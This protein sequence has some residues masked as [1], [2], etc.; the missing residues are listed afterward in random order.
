M[1]RIIILTLL[2]L[3]ARMVSQNYRY[4]KPGQ[5]FSSTENACLVIKNDK[6]T[7]LFIDD[8]DKYKAFKTIKLVGFN[9]PGFD[10][11]S[12][13][14]MIDEDFDPKTLI[15]ENCDLSGLTEPLDMFNELE[16][17]QLLSNSTFYENTLFEILKDCPVKK[18]VIQ[19]RDAELITDSLHFL[20]DLNSLRLSSNNNFTLP[21]KTA[22]IQIDLN[23]NVHTIDLAYYGNFYKENKNKT[24]A[25]NHPSTVKQTVK[26]VPMACIKQ[27]I[28]GI[29]INDTVYNFNAMAGRKMLYESGSEITI[30]K[31]AFVTANGQNYTGNVK[32]F[33]R[34][35]RNPV[36][37]MLSGIPM[38]T[39]VGD[40]MELF[41]S[42]GMYEINAFD[43]N[44]NQLQARSDTSI[45]INFA[46]TDTS[47]SFKFYS[48][49]DNGS[50]TTTD[51]AVKP[52]IAK[53]DK[54]LDATRAVRE[55][56]GYLLSNVKNMA[57]TTSYEAR[58]V[59][60]NYLYTYRKDNLEATKDSVRYFPTYGSMF[61]RK[62]SRNKSFFRVKF[63][64]LTKDKE[65]IFTIVKANKNN[66]DVPKHILP[67]LNR[68]YLYTGSLTKEEFRATYNRKL[69]C[70]DLRL[71]SI[72]NGVD[73]KI[74]TDISFINLKGKAV[75]LMDDGTCY[76]SKKANTILCNA[77][78][79][80]LYSEAKRFNKKDRISPYN[81]NDLNFPRITADEKDLLAYNY[82][83]KYQNKDEKQ[84]DFSAW[85][86]YIKKV[87]PDYYYNTFQNNNE[88]GNALVKSGLGV[89]NIDA[90]IHSGQMEDILVNYN[91]DVDSLSDQYNA[92]L[93]KSINTSYP[94]AKSYNGNSLAGFYFKRNENYIVRFSGNG[95]MQVT[96]PNELKELKKGNNIN[97][98]YQ[99]QHNVKNLNSNDITR[100][101]LD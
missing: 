99:Q 28:P 66:Y 94:I 8:L 54:G 30:D 42:G 50:W 12:L 85:K 71:N 22:K 91:V 80:A 21:N 25:V 51:V 89:K 53:K 59:N 86:S 83:K 1:Q 95:Y 43:A 19:K 5:N 70:W 77:V 84:M 88:V 72:G 49:N 100:L 45:K 23:N 32:L 26:S 57:D 92:I 68:T 44:G 67:L 93:F 74:K 90:Y 52:V 61:N 81:Y 98:A 16:E 6:R 37:I 78:L 34:E 4:Y 55:Y 2:C 15:F 9:K 35:F 73:L 82:S 36:E 65:I 48:L 38:S 11:D 18:L 46:L 27:P 14:T 41:K 40:K 75:T 96:K 97:I 56:Y 64:K 62:K 17:V 47:E 79:R 39:K 7:L 24:A 29:D 13:I 58:F 33:Y 20:K 69:L 3:T 31:N 63:V 87:Y 10:M 76:V 101:I 60:R